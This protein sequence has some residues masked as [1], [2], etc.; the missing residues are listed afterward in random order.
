[1][2]WGSRSCVAATIVGGSR[3]WTTYMPGLR[4]STSEVLRRRRTR[5]SRRMLACG[6]MWVEAVDRGGSHRKSWASYAYPLRWLDNW[7]K[8][9]LYELKLS[10]AVLA[11]ALEEPAQAPVEL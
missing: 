6:V 1:M 8:Q 7:C 9:E 2:R 4:S 11:G 3:P 5:P 10:H